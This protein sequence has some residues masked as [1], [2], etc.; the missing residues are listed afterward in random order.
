NYFYKYQHE[1]LKMH[2]ILPGFKQPIQFLLFMVFFAPPQIASSQSDPPGD[3]VSRPTIG[4]QKVLFIR[5][6]YPDATN[7]PL[8]AQQAPEHAEK[9]NEIFKVN[10][11]GQLTLDIDITPVL[12]MPQPTSFYQLENRLSYVRIRADAIKVAEDAGFLESDYDREAIFTKRLWAQE[13]E[14]VGGINIRTY[15]ST[16]KFNNPAHSAHE[17][18]HTLDWRHANFWRVTSANPVDTAGVLIQY[19]DKFDIMGD[20]FNFHHFNPWYKSR[21]GWLPPE[22]ILTVSESGIYIIRAL[23]NSPLSG[24]T[25]N[26]YT[27]LRIRRNPDT[28]YWIYYRSKADSANTGALIS[29]I[30][31][32]NASISVLLD[33][34]P[35]SKFN[36]KRDHVDA[37]L[38]PGKTIR[39]NEAGIEITVLEKYDDSLRVQVV[40]P[41]TPIDVLPVID[42]V[43]PA[44]GKTVKGAIDYEVTAFDPDVGQVNGA[45]IDTVKFI[46]GYSEGDNFWDTGMT[47]VPL[48][49][50]IVISPPYVFHVETDSLP[51]EAY[52]L[53]V[54]AISQNGGI[55]RATFTHIIDNTGP[56]VPSAVSENQPE[57]AR[58]FHL[59]QNYPN[60]FNPSTTINYFVDRAGKVELTIYNLLGKKIRTLVQAN[61][62]AGE[63]SALWDGK[64]DAGN[65][66][67][68]GSYYYKLRI[69]KQF[70]TKRMV[71]LK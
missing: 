22:S 20:A 37:A 48:L 39:D 4:V 17:F 23:E 66:M 43:T 19:G 30:E 44:A 25:N 40:V 42:I 45:G 3:M 1:V 53:Q 12:M 36:E 29:R 67:T 35:G 5:V 2:K 8:T 69:G 55:N 71:L 60:P 24:S 52:R 57:I 38:V 27:A 56:S 13:P 9:L 41:Q 6:I 32:R 61:K 33:M 50:K 59:Q 18:G 63:Y 46:L 15:F 54:G 16:N 64:D 7:V 28:E 68:S 58:Q 51:D 47:F 10:S 11:Y 34:T 65:R 70:S 62:P 49:Q 31:P 21:V 14:G 26:T